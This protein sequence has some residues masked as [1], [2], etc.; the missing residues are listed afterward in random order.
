MREKEIAV[1]SFTDTGTKL[2]RKIC[3][4]LRRTGYRCAGAAPAKFLEGEELSP[5]GDIHVWTENAWKSADALIFV[6]AAGIAVRLTAP[7]VRDKLTDPAVLVLDEKG[8]YVIPLLSGHV[9]GANELAV[10][11]AGELRAVPVL[12]TA[13]DVQGKFAVDVFAVR[14]HLALTDRRLAKEVSAAVLAG[15]K[16]GMYCQEE[17]IGN[18][19]LEAEICDSMEALSQYE[20][21]I[22]VTD[23]QTFQKYAG[24]T[25]RRNCLWLYYKDITV[26]IG[27]RKDAPG[28]RIE[29]LVRE[30]LEQNGNSM[31]ELCLAASIDL[32]KEEPGIRDFCGKYGIPFRTYPGEALGQIKAVSE[33]SEFVRKVTGIGNVC[34]RAAIAGSGFGTV[35]QA[36]TAKD[37]VTAALAR[38]DRRIQFEK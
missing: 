37:G 10:L 32:K 1:I 24:R 38:P 23:F 34:E 7:F 26:G 28:E 4:I 8:D 6:G 20:Y 2:N 14:N 22:A 18:V 17:I 31:E 36:K 12:T 30:I 13:T 33:E 5:S 29:H 9:G 3:G 21:S 25:K 15:K 16:I 27:C 11:L 19:P 35:I